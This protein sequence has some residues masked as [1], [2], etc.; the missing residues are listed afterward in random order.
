MDGT[1]VG[2]CGNLFEEI[3]RRKSEMLFSA[4]NE[5]SRVGN[6]Y[7]FCLVLRKVAHRKL[8]MRNILF[9]QLCI[10]KQTGFVPLHCPSA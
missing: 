1:I 9:S 2:I 6:Q 4:Q 8:V 3:P 7:I 5:T 10:P